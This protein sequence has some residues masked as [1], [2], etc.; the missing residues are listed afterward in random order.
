MD[1]NNETPLELKKKE[2]YDCAMALCRKFYE[3]RVM[4]LKKIIKQKTETGQSYERELEELHHCIQQTTI[5]NFDRF[6]QNFE[7][8]A[9]GKQE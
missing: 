2:F 9:N 7:R 3:N 4:E 5:K 8:R 1:E 6:Q